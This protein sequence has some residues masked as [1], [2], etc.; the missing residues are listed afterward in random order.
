MKFSK[1]LTSSK[2]RQSAKA[3]RP[4]LVLALGA[5]L[6]MPAQAHRGWI[7]PSAT[8]LSGDDAWV[9]FDAAISNT[10]F[11]ADHF[12]MRADGLTVTAPNGETVEVENLHSGKYRTVFDVNLAQTGTYKIGTVSGG[13]SA[14]WEN[15]Q[16]ERQMWPGRGQTANDADFDQHVPRDARNLQVSYSWRRTETFVTSGEPSDAVFKPSNQG[17]ELVPMTHPNDLFAGEQADFQLLIDGEPA[18]GAK[19]TVIAGNMRYRNS[20]NEMET[21]A[22]SEGVFSIT[23]PEAGMYWLSASYRDDKAK[24]PATLRT[25]SYVATLEVLPE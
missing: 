17:L 14:R 10:L 1:N 2:Y 24:A 4:L 7:V 22:D 5:S 12:P 21:E 18:V 13:L 6:V 25:G 11:H 16:G 9:T 3:L 23:W 15:E 20:Q 19:V 8:V